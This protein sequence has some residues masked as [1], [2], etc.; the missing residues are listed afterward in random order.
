ME[1]ARKWCDCVGRTRFVSGT[2]ALICRRDF[3]GIRIS[4]LLETRLIRV[5]VGG[6]RDLA[7]PWSWRKRRIGRRDV[8]SVE[9]EV[10]RTNVLDP[11][12][13]PA[14]ALHDRA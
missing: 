9:A 4:N 3:G 5:V 10:E 14:R 8:A 1:L 11:E 2:D 12:A 7:G 13:H 6:F